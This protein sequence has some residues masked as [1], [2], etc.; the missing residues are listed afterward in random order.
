LRDAFSILNFAGDCITMTDAYTAHA[1]AP[2]QLDI[3]ADTALSALETPRA[4]S[5]ISG[6]QTP[7]GLSTKTPG[8]LSTARVNKTPGAS[9]TKPPGYL[10]TS[11]DDQTPGAS[12]TKSPG[13]LSPDGM[14]KFEARR[15]T[16]GVTI[17]DLCATA[18]IH[19]DTYRALRR[20]QNLARPQTMT[21]LNRALAQLAAG[22]AASEPKTLCMVL[23]R[24]LTA[25]MARS[26]G[27]DPA[28]ILGQDFRAENTNDP[29]WLQAA[30][31]RRCAIYLMVEG[32]EI[33]KAKI[34]AALGLTRQAIHK[35]VV[36]IEGERE[37]DPEFDR[38]MQSM[39]EIVKV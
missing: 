17:P 36:N 6:A 25:Q 31:L 15:R 22:G 11:E 19:P 3:I 30:R 14:Q 1:R 32:V 34:G 38:L 10:S 8:G 13:L 27:A 18:K 26:I 5:T 16:Q 39:I 12:S 24:V 35:C 2:K 20:G 28:K 23:L 7:R 37:A 29:L 9:S 33:G 21:V 4:L